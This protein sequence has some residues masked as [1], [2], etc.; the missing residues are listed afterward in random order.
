MTA[1]SGPWE[2][3]GKGGL[4][5]IEARE[6]RALCVLGSESRY[7]EHGSF[8]VEEVRTIMNGSVGSEMCI[9]YFIT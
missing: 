2:G 5:Y 1:A 6:Q 3:V 7:E 9:T 8:S 4:E